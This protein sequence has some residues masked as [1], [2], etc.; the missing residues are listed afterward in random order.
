MFLLLTCTS[1]P[2]VRDMYPFYLY[3]RKVH[4]I[5]RIKNTYS[6]YSKKTYIQDMGGIYRNFHPGIQLCICTRLVSYSIHAS[7]YNLLHILLFCVKKYFQFKNMNIFMRKR[8]QSQLTNMTKDSCP[9]WMTFTF[10]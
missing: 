6:K 7:G 2:M 9:P 10:L 1:I 4:F 8:R 3:I 5:K